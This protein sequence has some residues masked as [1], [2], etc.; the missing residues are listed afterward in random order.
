MG[1][2][3]S[4]SVCH[5][6]D[7]WVST[8][9]GNLN[10]GYSYLGGRGI[11]PTLISTSSLEGLLTCEQYWFLQIHSPPLVALFFSL[12]HSLC[13]STKIR[14]YRSQREK[15]CKTISLQT[16]WINNRAQLC[17]SAP[18]RPWCVRF[19]SLLNPL[20]P[21]RNQLLPCTVLHWRDQACITYDQHHHQHHPHDHHPHQHYM[22]DKH[23]H[24]DK[25]PQLYHPQ[26]SFKDIF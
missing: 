8:D 21:A 25:H 10:A 22:H 11:H 20:R 14:I 2:W 13:Y 18:V 17:A 19:N 16:T 12:L 9:C 23:H 1:W 6:A 4:G 5:K 24:Q 26:T 3:A 15:I 7:M